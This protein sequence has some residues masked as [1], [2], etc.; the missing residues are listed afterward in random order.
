LQH[1]VT[2]YFNIVYVISDWFSHN[3]IGSRTR[4]LKSDAKCA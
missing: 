3:F 4:K 1:I 2:Y